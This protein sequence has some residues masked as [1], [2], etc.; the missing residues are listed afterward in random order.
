MDFTDKLIKEQLALQN[1]E[2]SRRDFLS[3]IGAASVLSIVPSMANAEQAIQQAQAATNND[4]WDK[5]RSLW[6]YRQS[7]R[8]T[9][10]ATYFKDGNIQGEDYWKICSLMRDTRENMMF[11]MSVA[12]LDVLR[13]IQGFYEQHGWKY[14]V[15]VNSG[16]RTEKTNRKLRSE[17]AAK[18]SMH[19]VGKAVDISFPGVPVRDIG[20]LGLYFAQGGVGFY[21]SSGFTHLDTGKVRSWRGR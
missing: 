3:L 17:G 1:Q 4:F 21:E 14:P 2:N 8:E 19:L 6:L 11:P 10:K 7:T 13:G 15:V 5:P 16:Y 12:L 20:K 9:I 18:N